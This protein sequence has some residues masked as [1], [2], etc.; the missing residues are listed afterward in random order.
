[1]N[2]RSARGILFVISAPSGTGKS[3]LARMLIERTD[4]LEFSISYTTRGRRADEED[5]KQYHFIDDRRF[6]EMI[7]SG[8]LLEWAPVFEHRYGTGRK[9][10]QDLLDGGIDL[11]L[12]IDI[13]GADQVR[14]SGCETVSIIILPPD[15]GVLE[16]RLRS[17][18][19]DDSGQ[20]A[21]RL[22][23]ARQE[24]AE[25]TEYDYMVVNDDLEGALS[26]LRSI[27]VAERNR[28]RR[29]THRAE[30]IISTFP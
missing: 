28:V 4:H 15:F 3:T 8:D 30:Q 14:R 19:S 29:N 16:D 26:E 6:D 2:G 7:A 1:M 11:L 10:T 22:K 25:Y 27:V 13:Q 23:K 24:A 18:G 9:A 5:G 21:T 12:D 20:V 17:R